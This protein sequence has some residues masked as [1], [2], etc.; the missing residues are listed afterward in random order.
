MARSYGQLAGPRPPQGQA[1]AAL[2]YEVGEIE[3]AAR[4]VHRLSERRARLAQFSEVSSLSLQ[5]E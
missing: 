5:E 2:Q 3:D 4:R 1:L